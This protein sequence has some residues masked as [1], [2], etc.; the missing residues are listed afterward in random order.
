MKLR[1]SD[2]KESSGR[3]LFNRK[4]EKT[5]IIAHY[6]LKSENTL[7]SQNCNRSKLHLQLKQVRPDIKS[8]SVTLTSKLIA[9]ID[10]L[11]EVKIDVVPH[12]H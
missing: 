7:T 10:L 3:F 4:R 2:E 5:S 12:H 11:G 1:F 8:V 6:W 9:I